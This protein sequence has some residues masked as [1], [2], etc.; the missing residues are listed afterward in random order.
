MHRYIF[1]Y[2]IHAA[3]CLISKKDFEERKDSSALSVAEKLTTAYT[4]TYK[5]IYV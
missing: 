1:R 5:C 3:G 2:L 4:G